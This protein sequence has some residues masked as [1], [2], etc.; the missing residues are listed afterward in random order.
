MAF[1]NQDPWRLSDTGCM[2]IEIQCYNVFVVH[3][4][5]IHWSTKHSRQDLQLPAPL[6]LSDQASLIA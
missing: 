1:R 6:P 2:V 5:A 3:E 4:V